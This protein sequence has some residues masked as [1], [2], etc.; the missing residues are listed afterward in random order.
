MP[1][2]SALGLHSRRR[3]FESEFGE[4][5]F[6]RCRLEAEL[7]RGASHSADPP[8][9][10]LEDAAYVGALDVDQSDAAPSRG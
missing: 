2:P 7:F 5:G 4:T 3:P 9:R 10:A 1:E 6:E 8:S